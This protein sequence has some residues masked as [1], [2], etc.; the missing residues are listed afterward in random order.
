MATVQKA[1]AD[2]RVGDMLVMTRRINWRILSLRPYHG[3]PHV[4]V[5]GAMI[6]ETDQ[7]PITLDADQLHEVLA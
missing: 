1:L 2:L 4:F 7:G 6:A 5:S 3:L